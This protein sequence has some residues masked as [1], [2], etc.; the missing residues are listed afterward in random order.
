MTAETTEHVR[1][2]REHWEQE[3]DEYQERNRAQLNRWDHLGWG[4]YDVAE[5]E[6][7]ALGDVAGLRALGARLW[8][9][10]VRDQGGDAGSEGDRARLLDRAAPAWSGALR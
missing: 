2:N 1:K 8:R 9:V 10:P 4:V 7:R 6:I 3:S 5:D